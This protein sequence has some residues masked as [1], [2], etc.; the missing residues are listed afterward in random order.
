M[1]KLSNKGGKSFSQ[2]S[3]RM[4][5]Q[6]DGK[7]N[8]E[9]YTFDQETARE[10]L[11]NMIV[12][13]DYPL[14]MVDHAGFR[15]FVHTVQPLFTLHTRNTYRKD[16]IG[17][18]DKEKKVDVE[19]MTMLQSRVAVTIDMWTS[20]NQKKGYL[21]I[22]GHF[23]DESWKLRNILMGYMVESCCRFIAVHYSY[24]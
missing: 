13:H 23:V 24:C 7:V 1:I 19:Y 3:L 21:A 11:G 16:I 10:E 17:R 20:D 6:P 15:R 22:T 8:V 5:A 12:L 9:N 2:S 4:T 18:Y 14:S